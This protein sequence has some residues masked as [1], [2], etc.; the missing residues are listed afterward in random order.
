M[1]YLARFGLTGLVK[2]PFDDDRMDE[3]GGGAS[4]TGVPGVPDVRGNPD[5]GRYGGPLS[6][7]RGQS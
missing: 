6:G 7:G 5:G 4:G 3:S 1:R 2:A